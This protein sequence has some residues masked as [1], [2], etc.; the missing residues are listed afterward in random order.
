MASSTTI[1]KQIIKA[2]SDII[3][4]EIPIRYI[5]PKEAKSAAG[6][7]TAT[8][9]AVSA[10]RN[11]KRK[12]KTKINPT[13]P[14]EINIFNLFLIASVRVPDNSIVSVSGMFS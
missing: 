6:I 4:I 13:T 2:K 8:H 14:L 7:P 3:L 11:K 12:N 1:P 5:K 10:F 9:K